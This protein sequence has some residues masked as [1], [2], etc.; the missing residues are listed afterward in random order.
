MKV[1]V[2]IP[3]LAALAILP[4]A[5]PVAGQNTESAARI[6][7]RVVDHESKRPVVGALIGVNGVESRAAT[8]ERGGFLIEHVPAGARSMTIEMIGYATRTESIA[9]RAGATHEIEVLLSRE[10]I[11]LAPIEVS[12]RSGFLEARGFYERERS[13]SGTFID[14]AEIDRRQ[15]Q[16]LT[17]L[18]RDAPGTRIHLLDAG[19][20]HIRFNRANTDVLAFSGDQAGLLPGCEPDVYV[21]GQQ[22]RDRIPSNAREHKLDGF[23][24]VSTSELEGVEVYLGSTAPL[25]YQ[26]NSCGTILVWTRRGNM[27]AAPPATPA[28]SA[29]ALPDLPIGA[30]LR[31]TPRLGDDRVTGLV[32]ST[33]SGSLMITPAGGEPVAF[34]VD[35]IRRIEHNV[36][37]AGVFE[38]SFRGARWGLVLGVVG[39]AV[40][41]AA[42][43]FGELDDGGK[44]APISDN[45]PRNPAFGAKVVGATTL[46]G[47]LLGGTFWRY[48]KWVEIRFR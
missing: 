4:T 32:Q 28:A 45:S 12:V 30:R 27:R 17:D 35:D 2:S 38:R 1:Q 9:V 14:R 5:G 15:P 37:A 31:V 41:A 7:G 34:G 23:D 10:A 40:A 19:L 24:V 29:I 33:E 36:G 46:A 26:S 47:A 48:Q 20:R 3:L 8:D 43:E 13:S 11:S 42:E 6:L 22:R 16:L 25:Q 39:V 18:L 44:T 21:D